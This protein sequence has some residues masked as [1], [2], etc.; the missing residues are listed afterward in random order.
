MNFPIMMAFSENDKLIA[1]KSAYKMAKIL[2]G[3][4]TEIHRFD[5]DGKLVKKGDG[6]DFIAIFI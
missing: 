2:V 4:E 1:A 6:H 3:D 5:K